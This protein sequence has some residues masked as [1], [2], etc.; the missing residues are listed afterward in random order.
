[1]L[2]IFPTKANNRKIPLT[3][4]RYSMEVMLIC[5][6]PEIAEMLKNTT[7]RKNY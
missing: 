5:M 4:P 6:Q 7:K 1:M 3:I 2:N